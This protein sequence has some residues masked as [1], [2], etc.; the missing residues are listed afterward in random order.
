MAT[1]SHSSAISSIENYK[2]HSGSDF[3]LDSQSETCYSG[4][5]SLEDDTSNAM[6]SEFTA[7]ETFVTSCFDAPSPPPSSNISRQTSDPISQQKSIDCQL[8]SDSKFEDSPLGAA[9]LSNKELLVKKLLATVQLDRNMTYY[10]GKTALHIAC[11]LGNKSIVE[12]LLHVGWRP[13]AP[14]KQLRTP[15][16]EATIAGHHQLFSLL[17]EKESVELNAKDK[18]GYTATHLAALH[19]E[20]RCL[21]QL[22]EMECDTSLEDTCGRLPSHLAASRGHLETLEALSECGFDIDGEDYQGRLPAH[23]AAESGSLD[24]LK[25]MSTHG[26]DLLSVDSIGW[27]PIHQA[28]ATNQLECLKFFTKHGSK[29]SDRD[30]RGRNVAHIA[31]LNASV[32]CLHW[33]LE[34]IGNSNIRDAN[35]NTLAH[36]AAFKGSSECLYCIMQHG[37]DMTARNLQYLTPLEIAKNNGKVIYW[38]KGL[39]GEIQCTYCKENMLET[40]KKDNTKS[41]GIHASIET[42]TKQLF[43]VKVLLS[44]KNCG[45]KTKLGKPR[46]PQGHKGPSKIKDTLNQNDYKRDMAALF[47]GSTL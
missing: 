6:I 7:C 43:S 45:G 28:A 30:K 34:R 20:T 41:V 31:A 17:V 13:D 44:E 38:E 9:I 18:Y 35:Q 16:H 29:I 33:I 46:I 11:M 4:Q 42:E 39:S 27:E 32:Q 23:Y 1:R 14:S 12:V 3:F 8:V 24:C 37:G 2:T 19:G 36:L 26:I 15:L 22:V 5:T 21:F 25:F 40:S 10:Q 47:Y